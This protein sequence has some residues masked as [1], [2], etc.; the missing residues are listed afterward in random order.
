MSLIHGSRGLI[1]FVHQFQP[2]FIEP[3]LLEDPEMLAA[4]TK[5]N[6]QIHE[7]APV[8]NST[9]VKGGASVMTSSERVPIDVMVKR[10]RRAT[11][12]FA[13]GMRNGP[14]KGSF[15]VSGLR[16][17]ATAE[18]L[19]ENRKIEVRDGKFDDA[20]APYDVHIYRIQ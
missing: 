9:T 6:R 2:R 5:I 8:L 3:A 1:Y 16:K 4:V 15:T 7:L 11:Y 10:H 17:K 13:V 12:V 18:V 14:S 20:F 19:G